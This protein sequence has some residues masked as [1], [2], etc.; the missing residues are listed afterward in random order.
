MTMLKERAHIHSVSRRV[1]ESSPALLKHWF[2]P[3]K[4]GKE[5]PDPERCGS[6]CLMWQRDAVGELHE[7]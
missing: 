5:F 1:W 2:I 7:C 6:A 4:A 3:S